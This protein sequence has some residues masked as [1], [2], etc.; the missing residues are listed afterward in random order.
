MAE[1]PQHD[2]NL[3][4]NVHKL[5]EKR[6]HSGL[7]KQY[8]AGV[9]LG[10]ITKKYKYR[11]KRPENNNQQIPNIK[12]YATKSLPTKIENLPDWFKSDKLVAYIMEMS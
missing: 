2:M 7:L 9:S 12:F 3:L 4:E 10:D 11:K 5:K 6:K 8:G 1:L